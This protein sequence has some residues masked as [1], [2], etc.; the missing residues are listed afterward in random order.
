[1]VMVTHD[2]GLK[3]FGNRVVKMSDGKVLK[4]QDIDPAI[5]QERLD[6]LAGKVQAYRSGQGTTKVSIREGIFEESIKKDMERDGP[7]K[8]PS[9]FANLKNVKTSMTSVRK[10]TD[11]PVLNQ[12][13]NKS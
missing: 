2:Q 8:I 12:R 1:M 4:I 9:N 5:R 7:P 13:F 11:Y 10:T 6:E 3:Y